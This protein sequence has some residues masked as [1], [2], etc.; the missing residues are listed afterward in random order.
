MTSGPAGMKIEANPASVLHKA[1]KVGMISASSLKE[2]TG[3]EVVKARD[4][5]SA[6]EISQKVAKENIYG[7]QHSTQV[8]WQDG[9]DGSD[10]NRCSETLRPAGGSRCGRTPCRRTAPPRQQ[11]YPRWH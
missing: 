9:S 2:I 11:P 8:F 1:S 5:G 4:E 6:V 10:G 3:F 7:D